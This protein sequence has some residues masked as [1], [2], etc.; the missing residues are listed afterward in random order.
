[1]HMFPMFPL[2]LP[3]AGLLERG[4]LRAAVAHT[5]DQSNITDDAY[6]ADDANVGLCHRHQPWSG[7]AA[8]LEVELVE[9]HPLDEHP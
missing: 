9:R 2:L 1:M 4:R 7:T 5:L 8:E 6:L 3:D